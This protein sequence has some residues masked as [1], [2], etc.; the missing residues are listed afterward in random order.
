MTTKEIIVLMVTAAGIGFFHTLVGP[1]HYVPF[2]AMGKARKWSMA[3]TAWITLLCGLGHVLSSV[4]IGVVGIALGTAVF[5]LEGIEGARGEIAGWLLL[6]FG[7]TYFA[8]GIHQAIRNRPHQHVHLHEDGS[9]HEHRHVHADVH[10]HVHDAGKTNITPWVLFTIFVFGPCEPLIPLLM[11]PALA[12][13]SAILVGTVAGVFA[14]A[15]IG[16]MMTMVLVSS[17]WLKKLP[18]TG[19]QRYAHALAG[20]AILMCGGAMTFFKL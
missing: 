14:V 10:T 4:V 19:L 15:T 13:E 20:L 5:R 9:A 6:I 16:T 7:L 12:K 17:Y 11:Y 2:I 3:K 18:L 8:W 1:D